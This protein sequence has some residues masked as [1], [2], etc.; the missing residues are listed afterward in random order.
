MRSRLLPLALLWLSACR[1]PTS[2]P[3]AQALPA[4]V[5]GVWVNSAQTTPGDGSRERPF[6]TLAEALAVRPL[7]TVYVA[8]GVY[9]GPVRLP[10]GGH[11]VGE[12][13]GTVLRGEGQ[14]PV[15]RAEGGG[16]LVRM[17]L[18]GGAWG[19]ETWGAL[20]LEA[21]AFRGQQE[22]AVGVRAGRL[23]VQGARFE[24]H[25]QEAVG[26]AVEGASAA[27]VRGST[28]TGSWRRG[29]H[30]RGGGEV[31]LEDVRFSGAEM[32]L[33]QEGGRSRLLRVTVE[34]GRGPGL[35]VRGGAI[36]IEAG[37][38]SGHEYG[39]AAQGASLEVRDFTSVRAQR[40][41][42]GLTRTTGRLRDIQVRE[43]GSF[44]A[45]QLVDSDLE[46]RGFRIEDVD[47]YGVVATRGH[48]RASKGSIARVRSS[49]GFTGEGLHLRGAKAQVE[50][51]EVRDAKGAGVLAAQGA[52]VEVRDARFSGCKQ[53]GLLVESLSALQA[54]GIEIQETEGPALAVLRD[55][56]LQAE[57]LTASG[58]AEGLVWAECGGATR[59]RLGLV[60][61][62]DLRG[63][64][65]PCVER[66]STPSVSGPAPGAG[67][68]PRVLPR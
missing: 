16:T 20:R 66:V 51:L 67:A 21:V 50:G 68:A 22:G 32:G 38:V 63:L 44:G 52:E 5:Q 25:L 45:L 58:L 47:A 10:P 61:S 49:D 55:G 24:T 59:V 39:L 41:G 57:A 40:A 9:A 13:P 14:A 3:P 36:D 17:T 54:T 46:L 15:V 8:S 6:R 12:G 18:Q 11:L 19:V 62:T 60:R 53:A 34:G 28:F 64:E 29:V 56:K 4:P 37:K 2:A 27:E 65:A 43:S 42:M 26:I 31:L 30:V 33:D 23:V 48:L 7:P 35:L 1:A